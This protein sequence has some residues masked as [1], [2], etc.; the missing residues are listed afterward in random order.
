MGEGTESGAEFAR[1]TPDGAVVTVRAKPR[2]SKCGVDGVAGGALAVRV[3]S[4]PVDGKA[5]RELVETLSDAFGIP[6]SRVEF[7]G[8]ES[9]KNKRILLRGVSAADARKAIGA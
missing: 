3:R 9:S 5:N 8:G 7:V 4:A 1:D 2:S 6:K